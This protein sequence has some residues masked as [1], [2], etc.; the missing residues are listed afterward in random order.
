MKSS[1]RWHPM[2]G[3]GRPIYNRCMSWLGIKGGE[4]S[5]P[6]GSRGTLIEVTMKDR[7]SGFGVGVKVWLA[8]LAVLLALA[9]MANAQGGA[10]GSA[11]ETSS[12]T[13]S[14][15]VASSSTSGDDLPSAPMPA[16]KAANFLQLPYN[17]Q[18]ATAG[19]LP[20]SLDD[21]ISRGID[22]NLNVLL[23][24]QNELAVHGQILAVGNALLPNMSILGELEAQQ[25]NLAALGFNPSSLPP[26]DRRNFKTIVKVNTATL[27]FKL[28]QQLFNVPAYYLWRA[29]E[30][31][32]KGAELTTL[33]AR[34]AV[35]L[36]VG[37][38][39]LRALADNSQ[40]ENAR[41]LERADQEVLRQAT[42]SHEAG[43]GTNLDVLRARV[44]L[45]TQQQVLINAENTFEKDKIALNRLIGIPAD[46]QIRLTD[47]TPY[48]EYAMMSQKDAL[49]LA[50]ER[51][52]DL[53]NL[54]A[55]I[56][57]ATQTKKAVKAERYP[58][59][60]FDG[61]YGVIGELQGLYH[62]SF[63]AQGTLQVPIFQEATLRGQR[64]PADAQ[65]T[66]LKQQE[67]SLKVT[68][69]QQ[70]RSAM[71]DV[72]SSAEQVKVAKSNVDL[73]TQALQDSTDRFAAGVDDNLPVVE[74]QATLANA[75]TR[76]VQTLYQYNQSKLTLARN[77]GVVETQY[78]VYLGR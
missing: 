28:S 26:E 70:I 12:S 49:A 11:Q 5:Q 69:D 34:G 66:A 71:L 30:R 3:Q 59:L 63:V 40:I 21:A 76:L 65:L 43:V 18:Q 60:A 38:Y 51:R 25:I 19:V 17:P 52:K 48:A 36:G 27:E 67:A 44:Q 53:L 6:G 8:G 10:V 62:G 29:A 46:Q 61:Y 14:P 16:V 56:D 13:G 58:V 42:A 54:E 72:Q 15:S 78:K 41:A 64:E 47:T 73:A 50:F 31:A 75:Q 4:I 32:E 1:R 74:A 2:R 68:I 57:I 55:Q 20:L 45:Q 9:P 22:Q 24:R 33:N 35:V 77:T 7:L 37:T 23:A 39:Y